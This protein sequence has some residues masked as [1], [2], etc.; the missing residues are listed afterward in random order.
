MFTWLDQEVLIEPGPDG[1]G[2]DGAVTGPEVYTGG[3]VPE[4]AEAVLV[5]AERSAG[6]WQELACL[7]GVD[8]VLNFLCEYFSVSLPGA[9]VACIE[10][11]TKEVKMITQLEVR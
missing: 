11:T 3:P 6:K 1:C 7:P 8:L 9:V 4:L 5:D 2:D 10:D